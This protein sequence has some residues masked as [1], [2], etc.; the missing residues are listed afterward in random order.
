MCMQFFIFL[1]LLINS[2]RDGEI[3]EEAT[4]KSKDK[5]MKR[6][7]MLSSDDDEEQG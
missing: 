2:D 3:A 1:C 4:V 6:V 5:K 7:R